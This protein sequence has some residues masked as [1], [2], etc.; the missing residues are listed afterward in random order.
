MASPPLPE[1]AVAD[2]LGFVL[3]G[4]HERLADLANASLPAPAR[5]A[6]GPIHDTLSAMALGA[7]PV[8]PSAA[9]RARLMASM[10]KA[11][12]K[13]RTALVVVDMLKDHLTPGRPSEVPRARDIVPALA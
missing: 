3:A 5:A 4:R 8:A 2:L 9:L 6:L 12:E 13:P 10:T 7:E 11:K 1:D